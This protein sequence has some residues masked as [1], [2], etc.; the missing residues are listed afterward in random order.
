M[1]HD[2]IPALLRSHASSV[3]GKI[4]PSAF[5]TLLP[6]NAVPANLSAG[7]SCLQ[8][9]PWPSGF[10]SGGLKGEE[11]AEEG[12]VQQKGYSG[13]P[14]AAGEAGVALGSS[15]RRYNPTRGIN[16]VNGFV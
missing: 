15:M 14:S 8:A 6:C 11:L 13:M 10:L 12:C 3:K 9:S 1:T 4:P 16:A 7:P 2:S 5:S